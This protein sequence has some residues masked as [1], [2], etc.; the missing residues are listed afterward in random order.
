[1]EAEVIL[2]DLIRHIASGNAE[3]AGGF[4]LIP[5]GNL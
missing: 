1:M 2:V 5:L 3:A 4:R